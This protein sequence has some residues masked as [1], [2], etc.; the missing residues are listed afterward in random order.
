MFR[1]LGALA[2]A[3]LG[4]ALDAAMEKKYRMNFKIAAEVPADRMSAAVKDFSAKRPM[5]RA[6]V[7]KILWAHGL[8]LDGDTIKTAMVVEAP[9]APPAEPKA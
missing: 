1:F 3:L 7:E 5:N 6:A 8:R 9:P 4:D 2:G